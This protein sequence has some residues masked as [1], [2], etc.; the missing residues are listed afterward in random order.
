MLFYSSDG[1]NVTWFEPPPV[2]VIS[3]HNLVHYASNTTKLPLATTNVLLSWNFSL[4]SNLL[5]ISLN[6]KLNGENIGV[7]PPAGGGQ[8]GINSQFDQRFSLNWIPN[9][10]VTL[11]IFNVTADDNGTFA[12][13]LNLFDSASGSKIWESIIPVQ[14]LGKFGNWLLVT[15]QA[16]L[17]RFKATVTWEPTFSWLIILTVQVHGFPINKGKIKC[18]Q[19][20]SVNHKNKQITGSENCHQLVAAD[21]QSIYWDLATKISRLVARRWLNNFW[22]AI[23]ESEKLLFSFRLMLRFILSTSHNSYLFLFSCVRTVAWRFSSLPGFLTAVIIS[24]QPTQ[25]HYIQTCLL[26]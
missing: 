2:E 11:T 14:V 3:D 25:A 24:V 17:S 22:T 15:M 20:N 4:S 8:P 13:E 12:C 6:L 23:C 9:E 26:L 10:K 5:F 1:T 19:I 16:E 21:P 7:V 18:I